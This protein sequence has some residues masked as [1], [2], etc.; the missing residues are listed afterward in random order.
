MLRKYILVCHYSSLPKNSLLSAHNSG[1]LKT[2]A[3]LPTP[4]PLP[5]LTPVFLVKNSFSI[6]S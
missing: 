2:Q 5:P 1:P 3:F 6:R 4:D